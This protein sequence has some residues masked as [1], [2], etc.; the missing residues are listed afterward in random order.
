MLP[1]K[2]DQWAAAFFS[3]QDNPVKTDAA[4]IPPRITGRSV[5]SGEQ[6]RTLHRM[7]GVTGI[8]FLPEK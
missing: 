7:R 3:Q 5:H 6:G 2:K 4:Q 8:G 1:V